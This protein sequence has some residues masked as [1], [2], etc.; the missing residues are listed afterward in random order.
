MTQPFR[1]TYN[2]VELA[3]PQV[4]LSPVRIPLNLSWPN[5]WRRVPVDN[6]NPYQRLSATLGVRPRL[7]DDMNGQRPIALMIDDHKGDS[8]YNTVT[9]GG[10]LAIPGATESVRNDSEVKEMVIGVGNNR[11][12]YVD[13][14][15]GL[16]VPRAPEAPMVCTVFRMPPCHS[17]HQE[18]L[19]VG[20]T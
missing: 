13:A 16:G 10:G 15:M 4:A 9:L 1:I 11:F 14:W 8:G 2:R 3:Q 7:S 18:G 6:F 17:S 5:K 19:S 12:K 20:S